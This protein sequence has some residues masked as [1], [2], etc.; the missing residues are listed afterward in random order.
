MKKIN[1]WLLVLSMLVPIGIFV[2][3]SFVPMAT[4]RMTAT[5]VLAEQT[6]AEP[7]GGLRA[8][9]AA[10]GAAKTEA[11]FTG[12]GYYYVGAQ[13]NF[14]WPNRVTGAAVK[15]EVVRPYVQ[16]RERPALSDH[17]LFALALNDG[18]GETVGFGWAV[19]PNYFDGT[20]PRLFAS[21][22]TN[23]DWN[24]CYGETKTDG[25]TCGW[26]DKTPDNSADDIGSDLT[27]VATSTNNAR[28]FKIL[29]EPNTTCGQETG[30]H[31][32]FYYDGHLI[33]CLQNSVFAAGGGFG[34]VASAQGFW[35]VFYGG[36][37]KPCTDMAKGMAGT[38]YNGKPIDMTDP[39]Y[40]SG[41]ALFGSTAPKPHLT[42]ISTDVT[43]YNYLTLDRK[44]N[45]SFVGGGTGYNSKGKLPGKRGK[46]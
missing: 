1:P 15:T 24:G 8:H 29:R 22:W 34:P 36:S 31:F 40:V 45:R 19:E 35:E 25:G 4:A 28:T 27:T 30:E 46:C 7:G 10:K 33:G 11:G 3:T 44:N 13:Q 18:T 6:P 20:V 43:A 41:M 26:V 21:S 14:N 23:D 2:G 17:S 12:S 38:E 9:P 5:F 32:Q 42:L 39:A 37:G 16:T